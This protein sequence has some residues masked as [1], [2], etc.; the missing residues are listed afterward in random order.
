MDNIKREKEM[1]QCVHQELC[2]LSRDLKY[3]NQKLQQEA[4]SLENMKKTIE[5]NK[6]D[7]ESREK[8]VKKEV[9]QMIQI[10]IRQ[11]EKQMKLDTEVIVSKYEEAIEQLNKENRRLQTSLK[12]MVATNRQLRDQNKKS[13]VDMT[14]KDKKIAELQSHIKLVFFC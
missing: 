3:R 13:D 10:S 14:E 6:A 7:L 1:I 4:K 5:M 12:D 11:K 8:Q 2:D 9:H